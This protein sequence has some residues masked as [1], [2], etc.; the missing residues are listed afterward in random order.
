MAKL[1]LRAPR[2]KTAHLVNQVPKAKQVVMV[3]QVPMDQL[4]QLELQVR[5]VPLVP[6]ELLALQGHARIF[7][8]YP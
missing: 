5:A 1:V 4:D 2:A 8:I 7:W 3:S 6:Q